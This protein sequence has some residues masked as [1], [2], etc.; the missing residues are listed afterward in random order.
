MS[1][2]TCQPILSEYFNQFHNW[3]SRTTICF[4]F[5]TICCALSTLSTQQILSTETL[6]RP[7][8]LSMLTAKLKYATLVW[9]DLIHIQNS[10]KVSGYQGKSKL[11]FLFLKESKENP[12][13][14]NFQIM[15]YPG[16]I[17]LPKLFWLRKAILKPLTCGAQD[18]FCRRW[19]VVLRTIKTS[20]RARQ[21][22]FC[23]LEVRAFPSLHVKKWKTQTLIKI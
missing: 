2:N 6:N 13:Q 11:S 1:L 5:C 20:K 12:S 16:G 9:R 4:Q 14:E 17:D 10:T 3:S 7:T 8:C 23:F 19:S 21:I 15:L 22:D 18:V